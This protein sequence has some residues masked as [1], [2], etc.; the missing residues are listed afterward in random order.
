[1]ASGAAPGKKQ[2]KGFALVLSRLQ[3]IDSDIRL[4]VRLKLLADVRR[5]IV[6]EVRQ[7]KI[8]MVKVVRCLIESSFLS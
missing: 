5:G 2:G 7:M 4:H 6:E 3:V 8:R 1:M